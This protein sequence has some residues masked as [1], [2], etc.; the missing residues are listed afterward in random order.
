VVGAGITL[1]K[2][3]E[4]VRTYVVASVLIILGLAAIA[5]KG[6]LPEK[7]WKVPYL[8]ELASALL[9]GGLLSILFKVFQEKEAEARNRN[10]CSGKRI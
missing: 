5:T 3:S 6:N 2:W 10:E 9:V 4:P 8:S 7:D 1:R